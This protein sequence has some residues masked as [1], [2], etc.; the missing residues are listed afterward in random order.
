MIPH[1]LA[2]QLRECARLNPTDVTA[3]TTIH[4]RDAGVL[5]HA[6]ELADVLL[7]LRRRA[8]RRRLTVAEMGRVLSAP[9][10]DTIRQIRREA[11]QEKAKCR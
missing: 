2:E 4:S 6:I 9:S 7:W 10:M 1:A 3:W 8:A 5:V 11:R